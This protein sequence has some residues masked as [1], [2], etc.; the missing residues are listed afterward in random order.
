MTAKKSSP[1]PKP[2]TRTKNPA[3]TKKTTAKTE[4][5]TESQ[6]PVKVRTDWEA[7]ER[8]YRVGKLTLREMA[9][10][11]G[12]TN[13]RICQVAKEKGWTRGDLKTVVNDATQT[14]LVAKMVDGEVSKVKQGLST[15]ILAAAELNAE[16]IERHRKRVTTASD[17]AMRMLEELDSTTTK[18][19]ELEALFEK[20]TEDLDQASKQSA[21]QQFRNL[22]RL[23]SRVGSVQ[24]L[25]DAIKAAQVLEAQAYGLYEGK[26]PQDDE[27][28]NLTDDDLMARIQEL[29]DKQGITAL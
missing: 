22:M 23:H 3:P 29:A 9:E 26:K 14:L 10:K 27:L 18:S 28:R 25:M 4:A 1:P 19:D 5:P 13:G 8:D 2:A 16:I 15:T 6:A 11:H 17:V 7:V 24:K 21:T 20:V 12:C